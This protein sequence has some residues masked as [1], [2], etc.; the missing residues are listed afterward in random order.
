MNG[1]LIEKVLKDHWL[2]LLGSAACLTLAYAFV[3]LGSEVHEGE[4][5]G[6]DLA[7]REW[8]SARRTGAGDRI[9]SLLT[10]LGEHKYLL[11]LAIVAGWPLLRGYWS[12]LVLLVFCS[13]AS[14]E[15]TSVLKDGFEVL[16]PP[17]GEMR[18]RS[19]SFPSGHVTASATVA[20]VLGYLAM[21]RRIAPVLYIGVGGL[22]VLLVAMSRVYLDRHWASDVI[23]GMLIGS[24]FAVGCCALYQWL[25]L[26]FTTIHRRR[27]AMT[28]PVA[29]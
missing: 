27:R 14:A 4:L 26:A 15:L 17:L 13:V 7:V 20:S 1:Q 6:L 29:G 5:R 19:F 9:F 22:V 23:G 25:K 28:R 12:W 8:V 18:H 16:R 2:M 11:P 10:R 21:R 3:T 24:T